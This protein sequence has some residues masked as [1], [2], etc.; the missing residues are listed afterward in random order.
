MDS[1][2]LSSYRNGHRHSYIGGL[3]KKSPVRLEIPR[4]GHWHVA[5]DLQ[6]FGRA[7]VKSSYSSLMHLKIK[8]KSSD[9]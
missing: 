2:N 7:N 3:A 8:M 1:S 9:H 5:V 6:G 4:S